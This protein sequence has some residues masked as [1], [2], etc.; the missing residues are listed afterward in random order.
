MPRRTRP[1]AFSLILLLATAPAFAEP[2]IHD[3]QLRKEHQ[4]TH[5]KLEQLRDSYRRLDRSPEGRRA[6]DSYLG[7]EHEQAHQQLRH[8]Q[9]TERRQPD[10][11]RNPWWLV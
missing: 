3:K 2:Y 5:E 8:K 1:P 10:P 7:Y 6:F 11:D 4:R 9:R